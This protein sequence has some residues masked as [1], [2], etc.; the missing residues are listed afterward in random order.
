MRSSH[1]SSK[2][3]IPAL[4]VPIMVHSEGSNFLVTGMLVL[5]QILLGAD[6]SEPERNSCRL[7]TPYGGLAYIGKQNYNVKYDMLA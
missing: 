7:S 3:Y 4:H 6:G 5:S 2:R 1:S